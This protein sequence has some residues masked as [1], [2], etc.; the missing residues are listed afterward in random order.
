VDAELAGIL[1]RGSGESALALM[2]QMQRVMAD[3]VCVFRSGPV[4][5]LALDELRGLLRRSARIAL[6]SHAQGANPELVDAYRVRRM[7][8]LAV[9][10]VAGA[11][12]RT[13]SRGAHFREDFP[14]RDDARWLKRTLAFWRSRDDDLPT[15]DYEPLEVADMELPPGWRGYGSKDHIEHPDTARRAAAVAAIRAGGAADRH[16]LQER[17]MP[18]RHLLPA[19]LRGRNERLD[20]PPGRPA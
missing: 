14:R 15:L 17:L 20:E 5:E 9:C 1:G 3:H 16:D 12:A 11:L 2:D 7:L 4:L 13:E 8:R 6:R 19:R 18:Y 10:V